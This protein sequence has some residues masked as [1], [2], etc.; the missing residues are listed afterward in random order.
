[1][2]SGREQA[3]YAGAF[4]VACLAVAA[5]ALAPVILAPG[6]TGPWVHYGPSVGAVAAILGVGTGVFAVTV[7]VV[8]APVVGWQPWVT[9]LSRL[10]AEH[11]QVV[12]E[13]LEK[14]L[15]FDIIH[16]GPRFTVRV[17]PRPGGGVSLVSGRRAR[18]G[19]AA[20][21]AGRVRPEEAVDWHPVGS[22][23]AWTVHAELVLAAKPMLSDPR[24]TAAFAR[25]FSEAPGQV[26]VFA[27]DGLRLEL[28]LPQLDAAPR[29]L[30]Q[31][32]EVARE[33]W[34]A[35]DNVAH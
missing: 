8:S 29:A 35:T 30:R 2:D 15:S 17:D 18:H 23:P 13:D 27:P 25:F 22:G 1:M 4:A 3:T 6:G 12:H 14:G 24:V 11:G 28:S 33:V 34:E 31:A 21:R 10:A 7:F 9:A 5:V 26:I 16:G 19:I 20:T 32:I